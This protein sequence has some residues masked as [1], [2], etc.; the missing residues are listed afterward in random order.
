MFIKLDLSLIPPKHL[1]FKRSRQLKAGSALETGRLPIT[2][3]ILHKLV[4]ALSHTITLAYHILLFQTMFLL[5]FYGFFRV[6]EL[7]IKT[8]K[9][10]HF[11]DLQ[12]QSLSFL[13]SQSEVQAAKL[14]ILDQHNTTGPGF[15]F[16]HNYSQRLGCTIL[17]CGIFTT[18]VPCEKIQFRS[19]F[20]PS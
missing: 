15:L 11:V 4:L 18:L 1:L 17:S 20:L 12:F 19:T 2:R 14:V 6:G 13:N 9:R 7:T 10:R 16:F 5:A 8:P 3:S